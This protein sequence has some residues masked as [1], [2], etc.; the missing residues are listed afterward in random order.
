MRVLFISNYTFDASVDQIFG[1]LLHGAVLYIATGRLIIDIKLLR[2]W[3]ETH[4][5]H[6]INFVPM[7]LN[8]L[9]GFGKR[10]K[11]LRAVISGAEALSETVKNRI[12]DKGYT[13]Y[14]QYGPTETTIDAL[15]SR[16]CAQLGVD[17]SGRVARRN[18]IDADTVLG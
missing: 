14:N 18:A 16:C 17:G 1:V 9:L 5:I 15:C 6:I 7:F 8:E 11:S 2:Q 10:L 13:L 3:I 4:R 12:M